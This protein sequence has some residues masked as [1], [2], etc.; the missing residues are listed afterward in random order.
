MMTRL[1]VCLAI[2]GLMSS[3]FSWRRDAVAATE[4]FV[5]PFGSWLNVKTDFGAKGDGLTDDTAALQKAFNALTTSSRGGTLYIPAGT[6]RITQTLKYTDVGTFSQ[7][8]II[9]EDPAKVIVKWG[10]TN[11][12]AMAEFTGFK[13]SKIGR[14]SWDGAGVAETIIHH[15]TTTNTWG[16]DTVHFDEVFKDARFGLRIGVGS[17]QDSEMGILRCQFSNFTTAAVSVESWNALDIWVSYST[18]VNNNIGVTNQFNAGNFSAYYNSFQG[19]KLADMTIHNT[20]FFSARGNYSIGSNQFWRSNG[21]GQNSAQV[22]LQGNVIVDTKNPVAIESYDMGPLTLIGNKIRSAAASSSPAVLLNNNVAGS[23]ISV[24]NTFTVAKPISIITPSNNSFAQDDQITTYAAISVT[25]PQPALTPTNYRRPVIEVAPGSTGAAIQDAIKKAQAYQGRRPVVHLPTGAYAIT[26]SLVIPKGLD[27]QIVGDGWATILKWAGPAGGALIRLSS[28]SKASLRDIH[29]EGGNAENIVI[30][31][32]DLPGSRI[33][34]RDLVFSQETGA[35]VMTQGLVNTKVNLFDNQIF[36]SGNYGVNVIGAGSNSAS[37]VS[38]I[39]GLANSNAPGVTVHNVTNGGNLLLQ[40]IW[41]EGVRKADFNLSSSG[42]ITLQG[43]NLA[44]DGA[45]SSNGFRGKLSLLNSRIVPSGSFANTVA[46]SVL[47]MGN[48][49]TNASWSGTGATISAVG[50]YKVLPDGAS[51]PMSNVGKPTASLIRSMLAQT[52]VFKPDAAT[53]L[54]ATLSDVQLDRL[55]MDSGTN[56]IR[57][58]V[59]P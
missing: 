16:S 40:D 22:T 18:F 53:E 43:A 13:Y 36:A 50:N 34:G 23:V 5:G 28:P 48:L 35:D 14:I 9:G 37:Q 27:V 4:E 49:L 25:A 10:G 24:G 19:S 20:Q 41:T 21:A 7:S 26:S 54:P 57:V 45:I 52:R 56:G 47:L 33:Q 42:N 17:Y 44:E 32:E 12:G 1:R 15:N 31:S 29:L 6:Y 59:G 51:G 3:C 39:G 2:L 46:T 58:L 55:W 11:A 30:G 8:Q 38:V